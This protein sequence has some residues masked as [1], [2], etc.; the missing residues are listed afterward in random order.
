MLSDKIYP[1]SPPPPRIDTHTIIVFLSMHFEAFVRNSFVHYLHVYFIAKNAGEPYFFFL[2]SVHFR[3][4]NR[5]WMVFLVLF[6]CTYNFGFFTKK[7]HTP[8]DFTIRHNLDIDVR[9]K[10]MFGLS[11]KVDFNVNQSKIPHI[12]HQTAKN[13]ELPNVVRVRCL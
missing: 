8:E 3:G 12:I 6:A 13:G 9:P 4:S 5:K 1:P 7:N 2:I 11:N 10:Q